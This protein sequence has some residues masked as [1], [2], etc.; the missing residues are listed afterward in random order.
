MGRVG[1]SDDPEE[2]E[3]Q[4]VWIP[5]AR[6]SMGTRVNS[7]RTSRVWHRSTSN[8]PLRHSHLTFWCLS[9]V[10]RLPVWSGLSRFALTKCDVLSVASYLWVHLPDQCP[11][12]S[13]YFVHSQGALPIK[14]CTR[15]LLHEPSQ[16]KPIIN[17]SK[18]V[19][20]P[21]AHLLK[22]CTRPWKCARRVQGAPLIS[23]TADVVEYE[24]A[25]YPLHRGKTGK[26]SNKKSLSGNTQGI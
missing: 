15:K 1:R 13:F 8:C 14:L 21:G 18:N 11:K 25:G 9:V 17:G 3:C 5:L 10:N 4:P 24:F 19:H 16:Y 26:M 12:L 20:T 6:R 2:G 23:D 22:S 7:S